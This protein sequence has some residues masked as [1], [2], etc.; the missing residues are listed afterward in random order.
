MMPAIK[1]WVK[2]FV[3]ALII[4]IVFR[5]FFF[6]IFIV[7]HD[8]MYNTAL[9]GDFIAVNKMAYGARTPI[10]PIGIPFTNKYLNLQLPYTRMPGYSMVKNNDI[11]VFNNP[12]TDNLPIDRK[13]KIMKRVIAIPGDTLMI[14]NDSIFINHKL[15]QNPYTCYDFILK[16]D[17][18]K[19]NVLIQKY[20]LEHYKKI[21]NKEYLVTCTYRQQNLMRT[22]GFS[23]TNAIEQKNSNIDN[24][25]PYDDSNNLHNFQKIIIP[26]KNVTVT[27]NS[28]N[29]KYYARIISIYENNLLHIRNDS[30][31]INNLHTDNYTFKMNYYF[32]L[33]D[34]RYN[35]IDSRHWGFLPENHIIGKCSFILFSIDKK[36]KAVRWKRIFKA[37]NRL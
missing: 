25:F 6:Q 12:Y 14:K 9:A 15:Y 17:A 27:I 1:Q 33:G 32:V 10:T 5:T 26:K 24:Y 22:Q 30:I 19:F 28:G 36:R 3:Y 4:V 16:T 35:S 7:Q 21:N 18:E 11:I 29:I 37:V 2:A 23:I 13:N 8:S 31:F 34:N 20:N